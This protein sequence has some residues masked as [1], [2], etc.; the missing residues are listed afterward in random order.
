MS[1]EKI[2]SITWEPTNTV[3]DIDLPSDAAPSIT[4][5]TVEENVTAKNVIAERLYSEGTALASK[6]LLNID[7]LIKK[8][9]VFVAWATSDQSGT[10][11]LT[12]GGVKAE[13]V[14]AGDITIYRSA[15]TF[16]LTNFFGKTVDGWELI[17]TAAPSQTQQVEITDIPLFIGAKASSYKARGI[18]DI[19]CS[20]A[21]GTSFTPSAQPSYYSVTSATMYIHVK[22]VLTYL[23]IYPTDHAFLGDT[24][25]YVAVK[26]MDEGTIN[27][28]PTATVSGDSFTAYYTTVYD[29]FTLTKLRLKVE[30]VDDHNTAIDKTNEQALTYFPSVSGTDIT[31]ADYSYSLEAVQVRDHYMYYIGILP[32]ALYQF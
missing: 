1:N 30:E 10:T 4:S 27:I 17:D 23:D 12:Y 15:V 8:N 5:L 13:G 3:Y 21:D 7:D 24:S 2:S 18:F 26:L 32:T 16:T 19:T 14:K 20:L 22:C 11:T 28:D 31:S 6:R 25:A 29:N 9:K